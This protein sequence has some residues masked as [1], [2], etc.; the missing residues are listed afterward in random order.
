MMATTLKHQKD[1]E[2]KLAGTKLEHELQLPMTDSHN[3]YK[4]KTSNRV[5]ISE[6]SNFKKKSIVQGRQ[7]SHKS[8]H[9]TRTRAVIPFDRLNQQIHFQSCRNK[10][11]NKNSQKVQFQGNLQPCLK[12][13]L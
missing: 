2:K 9:E 5:K 3:A 8:I 13:V 1:V 7:L 11:K 6:D 4:R 12:T 10:M